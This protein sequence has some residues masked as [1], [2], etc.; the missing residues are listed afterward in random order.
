ML[1]ASASKFGEFSIKAD[2]LEVP[3]A[4]I[5]GRR[6]RRREKEREGEREREMG[7]EHELD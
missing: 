1:A 4:F 2:E 3:V 7:S 5:D 6:E